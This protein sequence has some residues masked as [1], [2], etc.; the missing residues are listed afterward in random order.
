MTV[1]PPKF[2]TTQH[3]A[4]TLPS[5]PPVE[6]EPLPVQ[7]EAPAQSPEAGTHNKPS[8]QE[9]TP[10]QY[11]EHP[12][13]E[14]TPA[15]T[16]QETPA[17]HPQAPGEVE[18]SPTQSPE[19]SNV[20]VVFSPEHH[21]ST[22]SPVG[23]DQA[24]LMQRPDVTVKPVDLALI[25]T[26]A[27]TNEVETSPPQQENS[28]PS[29]VS[30]EQLEPLSVQQEVSDQHPTPTENVE[31]FPVQQGAP[32]QPTYP[33]VTFPN[34]EQVQAQHPTLTEVTIQPLDLEQTIRPE[35]T[36]ED[37][38]SPTMQE[39][40]T[41]PPEPPKEVFVAQ[42]PVYQNPIDPA[43]DQD[44]T[45]PPTSP[46]VRVQ[47]LDQGLT[48]T[49]EP[50][51]EA[52]HSTPLPE[53]IVPPTYPEVTLPNPEQ[54][55]AQHPTLTE[56]TVQPLDPE[57][58]LTLESN[59]EDEPSPTMQQTQAQPPE[60]IK[61]VVAQSPLYPEV[62]VPAPDEDHAEHPTSRSITVKPLDLE[63]TTTPEPTTESD[64]STALQQ[65]TAPPPK[66]PQVTLAQPN[67]TQVTV[68][69]VDLGVNISQQPRPSETVLFPSTQYS[70]SP[71]L[72]GVKYT[73]EKKQ[74]E[75]NATTNIS[76][77]ELCT[78]KNE[79]LS[80]VGLSPKQK[81]HRVPEPQ[82]N[83]YNGTFTIIILSENYL[84]ELHKDSFEGLLCRRYLDL[85]CNK[86][87]SIERCTFEPLPFLQVISLGCNL[88]TELSFGTFQAWHGMQFLHK[89]ILNHNPLTTVEDSYLFKLPALKYLEMGTTQVSL[90]TIESILMMTLELEK[91][92]LPSRMA[93]CLCQFKNTIEV[94]CKTVKLRC[95][96]ECLIDVTRCDEETSLGNAEG[97]SMKVLQ[98]WKKNNSPEL[99]IESERASSDKSAVSLS[100][101]MN[102]QLDFN[103]TSDIIRARN[104]ILPYISEG[105]LGDVESTLLPFLQV[106][107][108]NTQDGDTPLGLLKNNTRSPS[109]KRVRD[110]STN[111]NRLRKLHFLENLLDAE[112]QEKMDEV[113][114]EEKP[115]ARTRCSLLSAMYKRYI[116]Q[117]KL[118]NTGA[119]LSSKPTGFTFLG[120]TSPG[121]QVETQLKQQLLSLI[122]NNDMR[123][124]ISH[125]IQTLKIDCS[126]THVQLACANLIS[127]TGLLMK[128]LSKQQEVKVSKAEWDTDQW[129]SDNSVSESTEAQ[130]E[131]KEQ[132]S[133]ELRKE[134]P[135][136]GCNNKLILA[137]SVTVVVTILVTILCLIENRFI[138]IELQKGKIKKEAEDKYWSFK[139]EF[140][141]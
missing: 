118:H 37:E 96:S 123:R 4:P 101:F 134:V 107:F 111:K 26:P 93:C 48:T 83:A 51:M 15:T 40:L 11:P 21:V 66:H 33:E 69:P 127:R 49:P 17:Q 27:F 84:T 59:M 87:Q 7:Q 25:V 119:E 77:C 61:A 126:E 19:L 141:N 30:P 3:E 94:V 73:P 56:V 75:Q 16:Q 24:Q 117:K 52:E 43:P 110:N 80:C 97:S 64:H 29:T 132:E 6:V 136:C 98:A 114:K 34:P 2:Y 55:Q 133:S 89:L 8:V 72:P 103:N 99:T 86:I 10:A 116:F 91:L 115:A 112:T 70:V 31:P 63:L 140:Y 32:T 106:L 113:K 14:V 135:G 41:Q 81:L 138:L 57:L 47:P 50:T 105:N 46:S 121:D 88:L 44:H 76:I 100:G 74:P 109:V 125:V 53:T 129:K 92:V 79:T 71:G 54:V 82:P 137:I 38:P 5:Q 36:K 45:E 12:G 22:V 122:P 9:E 1:S 58:T 13:E 139:A 35:P 39:T 62:T 65:T 128:L 85:S 108:S 102:E 90:T 67:L 68:P 130:S 28:A 60:L 20:T 18:S 124:L 131:Q 23:Q 104:Y 120:F 78:C 42:P 95:D